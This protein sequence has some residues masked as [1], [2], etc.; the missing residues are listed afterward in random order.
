MT[1]EQAAAEFIAALND[2]TPS[3]AFVSEEPSVADLPAPALP[4]LERFLDAIHTYRQ[5][6]AV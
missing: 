5:R 2:L 1:F 6:R 3:A 4:E